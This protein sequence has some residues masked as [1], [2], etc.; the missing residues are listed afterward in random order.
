MAPRYTEWCPD[1]PAAKAFD[2]A[3]APHRYGRRLDIGRPT[4]AS[5]RKTISGPQDL[6][7][8]W[9]ARNVSIDPETDVGSSFPHLVSVPYSVRESPTFWSDFGRFCS[10]LD[11]NSSF[12]D[13]MTSEEAL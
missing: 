13:R 8:D 4:A 5:S 12:V 6:D 10:K 9:L 3:R 11:R 7:D 1:D 2:P